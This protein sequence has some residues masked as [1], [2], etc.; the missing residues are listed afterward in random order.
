MAHPEAEPR[1]N[2]LT[3]EIQS[4]P[5]ALGA[6][7]D[8]VPI[9]LHQAGCASELVTLAELDGAER[10]LLTVSS[11]HG[12]TVAAWTRLLAPAFAHAGVVACW[13]GAIVS[14]FT[15]DPRAHDDR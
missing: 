1:G 14:D 11:D 2:V 15:S 6:L 4:A 10:H 8:A 5:P 12:L 3:V 9:A 13:E 7:L